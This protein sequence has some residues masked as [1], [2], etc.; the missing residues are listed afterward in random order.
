MRFYTS[1]NILSNCCWEEGI[2]EETSTTTS[3][4]GYRLLGYVWGVCLRLFTDINYITR[5]MINNRGRRCINWARVSPHNKGTRPT[6]LVVRHDDVWNVSADNGTHQSLP[7]SRL[8]TVTVHT[9]TV[10]Q[11][12][13]DSGSS[14]SR[15]APVTASYRFPS[16]PTAT[17][18]IDSNRPFGKYTERLSR[19][20]VYTTYA[21]NNFLG[22][23]STWS[24][25]P[26]RTCNRYL[27]PSP[28][29]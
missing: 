16:P 10:F 26:S 27:F 24:F 21:I 15:P 6:G 20:C 14:M 19:V 22:Y 8:C 12:P 5:A 1:F 7:P 3:E 9:V 23:T 17:T 29:H 4:R 11:S 18:V 13:S 28:S 2:V 25:F